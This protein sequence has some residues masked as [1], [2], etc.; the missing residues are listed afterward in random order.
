MSL[1]LLL[2]VCACGRNVTFVVG[3]GKAKRA[4]ITDTSANCAIR[5]AVDEMQQAAER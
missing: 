2:H 4:V 3:T 1:L 5:E